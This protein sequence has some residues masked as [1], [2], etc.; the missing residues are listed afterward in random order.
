MTA[1]FNGVTSTL[2]NEDP[3]FVVQENVTVTT[4]GTMPAITN[5]APVESLINPPGLPCGRNPKN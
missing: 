4:A 3:P 2:P 5:T 1:A